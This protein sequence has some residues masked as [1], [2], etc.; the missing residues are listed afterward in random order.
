LAWYAWSDSILTF[1]D[2][3]EQNFMDA[4]ESMGEVV[5]AAFDLFTFV[6]VATVL[7]RART[8]GPN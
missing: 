6:V 1:A 7:A 2:D 4:M 3:G 5:G 8:N